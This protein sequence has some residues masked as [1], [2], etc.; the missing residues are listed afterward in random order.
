MLCLFVNLH[1]G[2]DFHVVRTPGIEPERMH[3][4]REKWRVLRRFRFVIAEIPPLGHEPAPPAVGERE[5]T[6][7]FLG[8]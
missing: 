2:T 7:I 3:Q 1:I 6:N 4:A 8:L 5:S